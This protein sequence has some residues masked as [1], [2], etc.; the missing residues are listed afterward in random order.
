MDRQGRRRDWR[1]VGVF[2]GFD[3]CSI[4][5][6]RCS[7]FTLLEVMLAMA[8]IGIALTAVLGSQSH[9]VSLAGEAKFSTTAALLARTKLAEIEIKRPDDLTED[10]GN[11]EDG[12]SDYYW[13]ISV[14]DVTFSGLEEASKYL[15][16]I[17]LKI[18]W[19]KDEKYQYNLRLYRFV[20]VTQ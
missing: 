5:N 10:S 11:F 1:K 9:S 13:E 6:R 14:N 4:K 20:P 18:S 8:I 17:D 3:M 7:G 16:Q 12:F 2:K 15:K 19:N